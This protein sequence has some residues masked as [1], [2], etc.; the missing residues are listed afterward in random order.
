M[1]LG[2]VFSALAFSVSKS[3]DF[4]EETASI[5]WGGRWLEMTA[6]YNAITSTAGTLRSKNIDSASS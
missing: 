5:S 1:I 4:G 3:A 6:G 2:W